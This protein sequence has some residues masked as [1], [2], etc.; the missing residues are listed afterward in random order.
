[1]ILWLLV[2]ALLLF[3]GVLGLGF[4][5]S[6]ISEP[7]LT[8]FKGH[9]GML[10]II[11]HYQDAGCAH[12]KAA[13]SATCSVAQMTPETLGVDVDA[14]A[15]HPRIV[16]AVE[17]VCPTRTGPVAGRRARYR[18]M[19]Y[20]G[21]ASL[22]IAKSG[23]FAPDCHRS[24]SDVATAAAL[25]AR[26]AWHRLMISPR[27]SPPGARSQHPTHSVRT[28]TASSSHSASP[29][30]PAVSRGRCPPA[31]SSPTTVNSRAGAKSQVAGVVAAC[32]VL[33]VLLALA[34]LVSLLPLATLAAVVVVTT[35]ALIAR[36]SF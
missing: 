4:I 1:M 9:I 30:S 18:S 35:L 21:F 29:T 33:A 14:G 24:S 2:H 3:A 5:T 22:G 27:P 31:G 32:T 11:N 28:A 20:S 6:F 7:I 15:H 10:I 13:F 34:P 8:G 36:K 12:Q 16:F 26:R 19:A 25:S 23:K 17:K